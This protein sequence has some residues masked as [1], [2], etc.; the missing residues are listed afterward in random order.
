MTKR[1]KNN[2]LTGTHIVYLYTPYK[3]VPLSPEKL[4]ISLQA[5]RVVMLERKLSLLSSSIA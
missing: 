1:A 2:A 4:F 3:G 5:R